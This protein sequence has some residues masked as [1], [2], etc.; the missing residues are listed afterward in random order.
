MVIF[1]SNHSLDLYL[2]KFMGPCDFLPFFLINVFQKNS[3]LLRE[4]LQ[5]ILFTDNTQPSHMCVMKEYVYIYYIMSL[6][7]YHGCDNTMSLYIYHDPMCIPW[8][9]FYTMSPCLYHESMSIQDSMC[10]PWVL[11]N[12]MH[13]ILYHESLPITWVNVYNMSPEIQI[14][15]KIFWLL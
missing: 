6:S 10:I 3:L 8:V 14:T 13:L 5:K 9:P 12:S 2:P 11:V 1:S 7:Q 15:K 4:G